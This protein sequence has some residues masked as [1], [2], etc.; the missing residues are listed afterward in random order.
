MSNSKFELRIGDFSFSGEG[1]QEW[2]SKE[3]DK[4]LEK[5]HAL[6]EISAK[7]TKSSSLMTV[8]DTPTN[9]VEGN[10]ISK[11]PLAT[12]LKEKGATT[13]QNMKFLATAAWVMS[14]GKSK[15]ATADV[16]KSLQDA[17]QSRLGNAAECLNQNVKKGY[18]EKTGKE[19]YVTEEGRS[20]LS[21]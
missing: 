14:K 16:T 7:L 15:V 9:F 8:P 1:E 6:S 17:Q 12:F 18:C 13:N 21:L 2:L 11:K 5:S 19:F 4:V 20:A 3:L 10:E